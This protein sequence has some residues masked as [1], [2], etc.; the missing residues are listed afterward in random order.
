[1]DSPDDLRRRMGEASS[2]AAD[3]PERATVEAAVRAAGAWAEAEWREM[4]SEG[5]VL[6]AALARVDMPA[7]L[8]ARLMAVPGQGAE[9]ATEEAPRRTAGRVRFPRWAWMG[10]AAAILAAAGAGLFI[11]R[12]H[13]D[14]A[15]T[16]RTVA[17][18]ALEDRVQAASFRSTDWNDAASHFVREISY[19]PSRPQLPEQMQLD[20]GRVARLNGA[21]SA[22]TKWHCPKCTYSLYQVKASELRLPDDMD[23]KVIPCPCDAT[24]P[25][26]CKEGACRCGARVW[27]H[28]GQAF[29][30]VATDVDVLRSMK[31]Q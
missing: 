20:G 9:T 11:A 23:A 7:G 17:L 21:N 3:D 18:A 2:L 15:E 6:R 28:G 8:E 25:C 12:A 5:D 27:T 1:M 19:T 30:L 24:H 22:C 31:M 4:L 29:V 14:R 26:G 13:R 16:V 10:A